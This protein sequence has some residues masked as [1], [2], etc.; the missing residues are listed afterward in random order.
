M[1]IKK[2]L[3]LTPEAVKAIKQDA[4]ENGRTFKLHAERILESFAKK[5]LITIK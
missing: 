2:N 1:R 5:L 4:V 3:E